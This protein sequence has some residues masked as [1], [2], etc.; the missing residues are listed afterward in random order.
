MKGGFHG[1]THGALSATWDNKYRKSFEPL[2]PDFTDVSYGDGEAAKAAV[3]SDTAAVIG[4]PI[5]GEAGIRV[6]PADWVHLL[7]DMAPEQGARGLA[8]G[9]PR[10]VGRTVR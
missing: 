9:V 4:E 5:Q 3:A 7:G 8:D 1:K 2:V 10:G 6:P